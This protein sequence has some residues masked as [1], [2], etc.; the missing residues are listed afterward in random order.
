MCGGLVRPKP[1]ETVGWHT[2]GICLVQSGQCLNA[3]TIVSSIVIPLE[4]LRENRVGAFL[5]VSI[6]SA[7]LVVAHCADSDNMSNEVAKQSEQ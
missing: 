2:T 3:G 4:T 6:E 7:R 1:G 5:P